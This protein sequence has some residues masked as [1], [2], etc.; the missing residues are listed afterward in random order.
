MTLAALQQMTLSPA[1]F[2]EDVYVPTSGEAEAIRYEEL[3]AGTIGLGDVLDNESDF[4]NND[5]A[6]YGSGGVG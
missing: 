4:A 5:S 1:S 6:F 2:S 3:R